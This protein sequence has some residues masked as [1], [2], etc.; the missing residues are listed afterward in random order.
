MGDQI[1]T[2]TLHINNIYSVTVQSQ[3]PR[4]D[5]LYQSAGDKVSYKYPKFS[6]IRLNSDPSIFDNVWSIELKSQLYTSVIY[7]HSLCGVSEP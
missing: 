4:T 1:E 5:A 2:S 3:N 7:I 6:Q